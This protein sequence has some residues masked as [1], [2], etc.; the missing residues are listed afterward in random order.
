[1]NLSD[2]AILLFYPMAVHFQQKNKKEKKSFMQ[3]FFLKMYD[4]NLLCVLL[5]GFVCVFYTYNGSNKAF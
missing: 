5:W 2:A 4:F 3:S 1:M